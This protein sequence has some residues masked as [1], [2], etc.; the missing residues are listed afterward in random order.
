MKIALLLILSL[1]LCIVSCKNS[2]TISSDDKLANQQDVSEITIP[3]GGTTDVTL[4][5]NPTTG[6]SWFWANR[7]SVRCVDSS[8]YQYTPDKTDRVGSGGV[9]MFRFK[10]I[11][12][13]TDTVV[14]EYRRPWESNP[15]AEIRKIIIRV[16]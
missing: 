3:V 1:T 12:K 15:P 7:S 2:G 6:Y 11:A 4:K 8:F 14:M 10:G 5:S 16:K 9:E 13:G